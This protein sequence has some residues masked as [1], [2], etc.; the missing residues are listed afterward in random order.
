MELEKDLRDNL[1]F[2]FNMTDKETEAQK[3]IILSRIKA[4]GTG[5]LRTRTQVKES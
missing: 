4:Q 5:K 1:A 2:C 3:S